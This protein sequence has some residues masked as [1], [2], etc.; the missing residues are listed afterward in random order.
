MKSLFAC[1]ALFGGI[2]SAGAADAVQITQ[3]NDRVRV[4][5][6]GKLFTEYHFTG[7]A[8][9]Y[10][11]PLL[12]PGESA[13]TRQWPMEAGPGEEHDH[14]HHRS[15]WYAHSKVDGIDFW[16]DV[17]TNSTFVSVDGASIVHREFLEV[18]SGAESGLIKSTDDWVAKDGSVVC[19]DE[20]T[21]T[22]YARPDNERLFDFDI[23]LHAPADK[24]VIF[25]D[26]KDG[27]M[28]VRVAE[29]MRLKRA[30]KTMGDGHIVLLVRLLRPGEWKN[31]RHRHF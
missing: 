26:D 23:T 11:Y 4:E 1:L 29:S 16:N 30:D 2:N 15:L 27:A 22:I 7:A 18:K 9:P 3:L 5:I 17:K 20:R 14:P 13:M 10:F 31:R 21:M 24:P 12:G 19:S 6:N 28:A 25:G 8:R